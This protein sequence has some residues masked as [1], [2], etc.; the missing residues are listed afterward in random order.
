MR[1]ARIGA[2]LATLTLSLGLLSA[3]Q[4]STSATVASAATPGAGGEASRPTI[5]HYDGRAWHNV[6][7]YAG[8]GYLYS[9]SAAS[10]DD[11]WAVGE[12]SN[13]VLML[14]WDGTSWT[15]VSTPT[16]PGTSILSDV[17]VIAPDY[18]VATGI[19]YVDE[20]P[21]TA[22]SLVWN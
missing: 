22:I 13:R 15:R 11:V 20:C 17:H 16:Y 7:S 2:A 4:A 3:A 5:K 18:A 19:Y 14:H 6:T 21:C 9:V 8:R 12:A 10:T 1:I